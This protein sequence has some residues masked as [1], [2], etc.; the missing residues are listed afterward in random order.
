MKRCLSVIALVMLGLGP[1]AE[2]MGQTAGGFPILVKAVDVTKGQEIEP[3]GMN[4]EKEADEWVAWLK[5]RPGFGNVRW[6]R[7]PDYG[8]NPLISNRPINPEAAGRSPGPWILISPRFIQSAST[9]SPTPSPTPFVAPPRPL[10]VP[11]NPVIER[12]FDQL[13]DTLLPDPKPNTQLQPG[14]TNRFGYDD[15]LA[16]T[17]PKGV[18]MRVGIDQTT[19]ESAAAAPSCSSGSA[20]ISDRPFVPVRGGLSPAHH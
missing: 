8:R 16:K 19:L 3:L 17:A 7:N 18:L 20:R 9:P 4:D 15:T 5:T 1:P 6:E 12:Q 2:S 13:R 11:A 14:K 10:S